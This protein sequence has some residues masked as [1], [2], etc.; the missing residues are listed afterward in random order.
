M[1][2]LQLSKHILDRFRRMEGEWDLRL[3]C[4]M[5]ETSDI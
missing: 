1:K 4:M 2:I 3:D 5:G